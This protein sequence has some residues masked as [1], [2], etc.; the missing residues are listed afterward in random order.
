M[1]PPKGHSYTVGDPRPLRASERALLERMLSASP[2]TLPLLET[3]VGAIVQDMNDG[4]MGSLR[5]WQ[6]DGE[7]RRFGGMPVEAHFR[8]ADG[9]LVIASVIVDQT[10]AVY[11][12]DLWTGD[13]SPLMRIPEPHEIR[14][15]LPESKP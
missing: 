13:G 14:I 11:E 2:A 9:M 15:G 3:I 5:F 8:D 7:N 1:R 4:G 12:L 6:K 10:G